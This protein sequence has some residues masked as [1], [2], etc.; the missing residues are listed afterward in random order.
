[1]YQL[2]YG[3]AVAFCATV[4]TVMRRLASLSSSGRLGTRAPHSSAM[5]HW[6]P[7]RR[8]NGAKVEVGIVAHGVALEPAAAPRGQTQLSSP[9]LTLPSAEA[10]AG[11]TGCQAR[12]R[13]RRRRRRVRQM[14]SRSPC[15][16][17]PR[18]PADVPPP[19]CGIGARRVELH[20]CGRPQ[21]VPPHGWIDPEQVRQRRRIVVDGGKASVGG[22]DVVAEPQ[23][24]RASSSEQ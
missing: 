16:Q 14:P 12:P 1:M 23:H 13:M 22:E 8:R 15:R 7:V 19:P 6:P 4:P 2:P 18:P 21:C 17:R 10:R 24:A 5:L 11:R 3:R 9:V 20:I